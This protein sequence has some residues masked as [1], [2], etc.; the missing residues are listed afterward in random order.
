MLLFYFGMSQATND[1]LVR[2]SPGN[3]GATSCT[4]TQ[5]AARCIGLLLEVL[6]ASLCAL[7]GFALRRLRSEMFL[8]ATVLRGSDPVSAIAERAVVAH[9][10]PGELYP[11]PDDSMA[12]QRTK[13]AKVRA[14][15]ERYGDLELCFVDG[16]HSEVDEQLPFS[17]LG[18]ASLLVH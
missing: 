12:A 4:Y 14:M 9:G 15:F 16:S 18:L 10:L 7:L 1:P 3:C 11:H 5:S 8:K 13:M 6:F 2:M 17:Y